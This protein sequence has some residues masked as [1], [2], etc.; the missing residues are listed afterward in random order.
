MRERN[1]LLKE[2]WIRAFP[3]QESPIA[4]LREY[5]AK[6]M[7]QGEIR[8]MDLAFAISQFLS[9]ILMHTLIGDE[10][11]ESASSDGLYLN[12]LVDFTANLWST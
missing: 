5:F 2:Q 12:K 11:G 7:A 3:V 8:T 4:P 9:G 6:R 1:W 10:E